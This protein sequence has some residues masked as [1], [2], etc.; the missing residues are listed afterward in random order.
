[1]DSKMLGQ[2]LRVSRGSRDRKFVSVSA[3][4]DQSTYGRWEEGQRNIGALDLVKVC[5]VLGV[6]VGDILREDDPRW[7]DDQFEVSLHRLQA[8]LKSV[9]DK[10][11]D[12]APAVAELVLDRFEGSRRLS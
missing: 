1:M 10:L 9:Q 3:G 4:F 12:N 6:S 11:G 5:E 8:A 2:R 7:M